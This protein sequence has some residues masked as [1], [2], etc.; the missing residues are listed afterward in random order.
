MMKNNANMV[1][2]VKSHTD[3]RG[4]DSF[5]MNLSDR[6]AKATVQYVIS[7]GIAKDRI[8]GKGYGESEPKVQCDKCT[9]EEHAK[10]RRSEFM[11]VKK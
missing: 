1:I 5:N 8:E 6:R 2:M 9:T 11:I 10:N 4:S 7:K 3:N